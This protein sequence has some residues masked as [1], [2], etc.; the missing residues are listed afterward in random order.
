MSTVVTHGAG[1]TETFNIKQAGKGATNSGLYEMD[2][3]PRRSITNRLKNV[4]MLQNKK[5]RISNNNERTTNTM[6][7]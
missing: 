6:F 7:P 4:Q 5:K 2:S 1:P 3:F